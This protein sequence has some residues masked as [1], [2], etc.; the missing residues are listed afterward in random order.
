MFGDHVKLKFCTLGL[1]IVLSGC[2]GSSYLKDLPE[3]DLLEA[4]LESQ[5]IESE[6]TLKMQICGDL[7][8]LGF[9]AQQEAREY[10]RELRRAYEYYERQTKPFNRKVRRYLNDY[11]TQY[12]AEH[13]E[14]L[15]EANFQLNMLP[16]R[17]ATAK[18]FGVDSKEVKEALSEP[19]PH[20]SFSGGNPN[21]VIMIQALH[22]KEKN[23]KSQCEKLIAQVF[24]D[25]IQPNFSKYGDEYK[26]IT[27]MQSLKTVD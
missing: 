16:A 12:G 5:R 8:S 26:K 4:A 13:R 10:G 23:I 20:F 6:M 11:D 27:G 25:N 18:F 21:S 9:E 24:D 7:Q 17:L 3:K 19:N 2:G 14:Q 15:R 1:A 22:E